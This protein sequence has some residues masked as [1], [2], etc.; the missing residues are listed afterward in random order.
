M[1]KQIPILLLFIGIGL[2]A[3]GQQIKKPLTHDAILQWNRITETIISNNGESIVYTMEPWKGDATLK[4][5][6][7]KGKELLSCVGAAGAEL[8]DNSAFVVFKINPL[9]AKLHELKLKKTKKE[10]M[11]LP[12]LGIYSLSKQKLDTI[13]KLKNYKLAKETSFIAFQKEAEQD[14]TKKEKAKA[15]SE[16]QALELNL[17]NLQNNDI[18]HFAAVSEYYFAK[19]GTALVFI[20]EGDNKDF[21]AGIYYLHLK[22][23][24]LNRVFTGKAKFKQVSINDSGKQLAFLA[25]TTTTKNEDAHFKLYAWQQGQEKALLLLDNDNKQMPTN[26]EIS[27]YGKI[28]FSP[29][30]KR[31]F[32]GIAPIK[33]KQDTTVLEE[34]IPVLDIW[35]WNED[36]LHTEQLHNLKRDLNKSY[37]SVY[38]FDANQMQVLENEDFSGIGLIQKGDANQ[39]YAWSNKPYAVQT[40][41]EGSPEHNDFYLINL[42]TGNSTPLIK[43][44]RA[45]PQVSP[46]GKYLY[47]YNAMDTSWNTYNLNTNKH[48]T[49]STA[50]SIQVADEENDIPNPPGSY[51]IAGWL[52]NDAALLIYDRYDIW[53]V[54]PENKTNPVNLTQNGRAQSIIYRLMRFDLEGNARERY[55]Q[56]NEKGIDASQ[57]A[58]FSGHN[59]INRQE[60]Y[61]QGSLEKPQEPK[62]L[63]AGEFR[64]NTPIKAKDADAVV[65][66]KENFETFPNLL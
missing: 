7:P 19:D 38:N 30:G 33:N 35:H 2:I 10:D 63:V 54:D 11:P 44:L 5:T 15:K 36:I 61:Y 58:Y 41:W 48:Y 40:M 45:R 3:I 12:R 14:S 51:R 20:S 31:I 17:L 9:E 27:G 26:W 16:K 64:L 49:V 52:A 50:K 57:M 32:F 43:D 39:A 18:Q 55:A 4:I 8:T 25:D 24:Q 34:D 1:K 22:T 53:K 42:E 56:A 6:N 28:S 65:F 29:Q 60:A 23:N 46:E 21:I 37:L 59:E 47:W 13:S 66:T 62:V